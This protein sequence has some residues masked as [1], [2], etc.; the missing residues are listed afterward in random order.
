M[1]RMGVGVV[2][3]QLSLVSW[4]LCADCESRPS[5]RPGEGPVHW[6]PAPTCGTVLALASVRQRWLHQ[7]SQP[8]RQASLSAVPP[9]K[10]PLPPVEKHSLEPKREGVKG[11]GP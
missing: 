7:G 4:C 9:T 1:D 2:S 10:P 5:E 3:A 11:R 6:T 8:R